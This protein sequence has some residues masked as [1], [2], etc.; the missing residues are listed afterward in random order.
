MIKPYY[1]SVPMKNARGKLP[2]VHFPIRATM[3]ISGYPYKK[4]IRENQAT[5]CLRCGHEFLIN[6][7]T[8][9][10]IRHPYDIG[11]YIRC[12]N[13]SFRAAAVHYFDRKP[14]ERKKT[15]VY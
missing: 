14:P 6:R 2:A 3:V 13:C 8:A 9:Y 10:Y 5:A 4:E 15:D 7:D 12:P 11:P 1:G